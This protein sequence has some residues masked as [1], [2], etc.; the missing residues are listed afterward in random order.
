MI[1]HPNLTGSNLKPGVGLFLVSIGSVQ[2]YLYMFITLISC[3]TM[4]IT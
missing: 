4:A 2:W 3:D 1:S